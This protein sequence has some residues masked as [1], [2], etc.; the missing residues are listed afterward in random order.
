MNR[1]VAKAI[2]ILEYASKRAECFK[3]SDVMKDLNIAK[4]TAFNLVHTLE[5][6]GMLEETDPNSKCYTLGAKTYALGLSYINT[7]G[8]SGI[9][10]TDMKKLG[11]RINK[12]VFLGTLDNQQVLYLYK[13]SPYGAIVDTCEVNARAEVY[14]TALGKVLAAF[15]PNFDSRSI[16]YRKLTR[17][18]IDNP[19][20]FEKT[21]E[22][23]RRCGYAVDNQEIREY[24]ICIAAPVFDS[25]DRVT[26]AISASMLLEK[27]LDIEKEARIIQETARNISVKLGYKGSYIFPN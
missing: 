12:T 19:S 23:V 9:V 22:T 17:N 10:D 5:E 7:Y 3:V 11:N 2:E 14:Y 21:L 8:I 20:D 15:T 4:T 27:D 16:R 26:Y 1:I 24:M 6:L 18:T 13:Y 25:T